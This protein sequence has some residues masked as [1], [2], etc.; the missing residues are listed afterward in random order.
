VPVSRQRTYALL[1]AFV[2]SRWHRYLEPGTSVFRRVFLYTMASGT[3]SVVALFVVHES[4][5]EVARLGLASQSERLFASTPGRL[6]MMNSARRP[7]A[8]S[9]CIGEGATSHTHTM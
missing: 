4:N 6:H 1:R 8:Q 7:V 5:V 2:C 3:R 9:W